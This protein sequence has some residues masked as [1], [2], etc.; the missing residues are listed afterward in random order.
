MYAAI[1]IGSNT[2]RLAVFEFKDGRLVRTYDKKYM[3]KLI[4]HIADGMLS[5]AA[6]HMLAEILKEYKSIAEN[7]GVNALYVFATASLRAVSNCDDILLFIKRETGLDIDI[8][9]GMQ[10]ARLSFLA[11]QTVFPCD[12]CLITD[13]GGGSSEIIVA[14]NGNISNSDSLAAGSLKMYMKYVK[15]II[16]TFDEAEQIKNE[17]T[18]MLKHS[19][20]KQQFDTLIGIGGSIKAFGKLISSLTPAS[21]NDIIDIN[22]LRSIC[23][24]FTENPSYAISLINN[25]IPD[26][27]TTLLPG[28]LIADAIS[29]YFACREIKICHF[30]VREGYIMEKISK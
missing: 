12:T 3:A 29:E 6:V 9:S 19:F 21:F 27:L 17:I 24:T 2:V 25:I 16:P 28:A 10:E 5:S 26:R 22:S 18:D 11:L 13:I 4:R 15:N 7:M 1:D 14:E 8:I 30:G 20:K 23:L